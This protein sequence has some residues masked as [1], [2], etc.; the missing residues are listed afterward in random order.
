MRISPSLLMFMLVM[1][2]FTP[3]IQEWMLQGGAHWYRPYLLWLAAI[4]FVWWWLHR[5]QQRIKPE[6]NKAPNEL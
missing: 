6:Q 3:S 1:F 2:V 4:I 5:S